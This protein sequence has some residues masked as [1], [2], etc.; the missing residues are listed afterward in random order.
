MVYV[1]QQEG[2]KEECLVVMPWGWTLPP[3]WRTDQSWVI[4]TYV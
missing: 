4:N 3:A 1:V 2:D